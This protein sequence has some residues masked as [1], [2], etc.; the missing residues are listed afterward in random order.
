MPTSSVTS[1]TQLAT[2][3]GW[4]QLK[5]QQAQ[6][7]AAAAEQTARSLESQANQAKREAVRAQEGARSLEVQSGQ[8][9]DNAGRAQ[10]GLAAIKSASQMTERLG[11]TIERA[12]QTQKSPE[13]TTPSPSTA[14]PAPTAIATAT[15]SP[16]INTQGETTGRIVN[17]TA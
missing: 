7:N 4:Q 14:T 13:I 6:R 12:T 2:Q 1:G 16:V 8:A 10:Q 15:V 3:L 17:T 9:R 5:V 11:T